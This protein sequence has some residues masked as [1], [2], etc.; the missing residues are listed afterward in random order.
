LNY[1]AGE[2]DDEQ[3]EVDLTNVSPEIDKVVFT[4]SIY[5]AEQRQQ[6]FGMVQR[7]FIRIVNRDTNQQ[8]SYFTGLSLSSLSSLLSP[9]PF[10]PLS[11][12]LTL[13]CTFSL[14]L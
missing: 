9:P 1:R 11:P 6:N 13:L 12:L 3:I 5:Q 4:V 14:L 7:A 2:G 8:V 10:S